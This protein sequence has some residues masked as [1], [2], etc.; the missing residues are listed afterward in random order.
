[1]TF[2]VDL[3]P[4]ATE[5]RKNLC[6]MSKLPQTMSQTLLRSITKSH[7]SSILGGKSKK[8]TSSR[9]YTHDQSSESSK[10]FLRSSFYSQSENKDPHNDSQTKITQGAK[11]LPRLTTIYY[12]DKLLEAI[13]TKNK[14][15]PFFDHFIQ[16]SQSL[17]YI[18]NTAVPPED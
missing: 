16:S 7:N 8:A 3:S 6:N 5:G 4:F 17:V 9:V 14:L 12:T 15:S 13:S 10:N 1:M 2:E 11:N 18:K